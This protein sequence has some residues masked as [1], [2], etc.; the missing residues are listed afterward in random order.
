MERAALASL[1][2]CG[3]AIA[4][5]TS[6]PPS[7]GA[8]EPSRSVAWSKQ[9][10][11]LV[12]IHPTDDLKIMLI[13]LAQ[14]TR[15]T[16]SPCW[17]E[18]RTTTHLVVGRFDITLWTGQKSA[19][20]SNACP[21]LAIAGPFYA[22]VHLPVP[23]SGQPLIDPISGRTHKPGDLVHLADAPHRFR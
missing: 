11:A 18:S 20:G 16:T 6:S 15:D 1:V 14:G 17:V 12:T 10:W 22:T 3:L 7:T 2:G 19:E 9:P 23:Y 21:A 8:T 4:A 13:D 5:C